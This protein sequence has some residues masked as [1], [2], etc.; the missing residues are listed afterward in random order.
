ML[1]TTRFMGSFEQPNG[2]TCCMGRVT[3][4]GV[5]LGGTT[6]ETCRSIGS[7]E[8]SNRTTHFIGRFTQNCVTLGEMVSRTSRLNN[9]MEQFV[10]WAVQGRVAKLWGFDHNKVIVSGRNIRSG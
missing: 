7:F 3:Q 1:H 5:S 6:H 4:N 10:L 2:T 8:Q 9:P